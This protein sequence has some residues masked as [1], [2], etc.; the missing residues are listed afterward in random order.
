MQH[1]SNL[2]I[3]LGEDGRRRSDFSGSRDEHPRRDFEFPPP[4]FC[5][6]CTVG[7]KECAQICSQ[8]K[9]H[10]LARYGGRKRVRTAVSHRNSPRL[11]PITLSRVPNN[12]WRVSHEE[13][14]VLHLHGRRHF[15]QEPRRAASPMQ[16]VELTAAW[17]TRQAYYPTF[18][19]SPPFLLASNHLLDDLRP[20]LHAPHQYGRPVPLPALS[21]SSSTFRSLPRRG[22]SGPP[23]HAPS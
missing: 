11:H 3:A 2:Y 20:R 14:C 9:S 18:G 17:D 19:P 16:K 13:M 1:C 10:F 8:I 23:G 21:S 12:A 5:N 4:V 7:Y 15:L 22:P 6:S